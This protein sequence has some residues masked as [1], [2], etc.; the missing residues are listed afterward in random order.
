MTKGK[1]GFQRGHP[2]FSSYRIPIGNIP[3]NKGI[4]YL[5]IT[6][7]KHPNWKGGIRKH[8]MYILIYNP[9]HPFATK[10]NYV[11]EHRLVMEKHLE[12]YLKPS[13]V[14]H[15]ING[16]PQDNRLNNLIV[17]ETNKEHLNFHSKDK[18][19]LRGN[20]ILN[21]NNHVASIK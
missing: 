12:R 20:K 19:Y 17:F 8:G 10:S 6:G 1:K 16:N 15:H 21:I 14:V 18:K 5:Q 13:E 4:K 7:N 11:P 3:W 2:Q 9:N